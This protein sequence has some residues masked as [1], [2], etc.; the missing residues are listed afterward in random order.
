[1]VVEET[2]SNGRGMPLSRNG[3]RYASSPP[4]RRSSCAPSSIHTAGRSAS[5]LAACA[6]MQAAASASDDTVASKDR[7]TSRGTFGDWINSL[8]GSFPRSLRLSGFVCVCFPSR[9]PVFRDAD[10][11]QTRI[12]EEDVGGEIGVVAVEERAGDGRGVEHILDIAH[13]LPAVLIGEDQRQVEIGVAA[14]AIIRI[15]VED[16]GPAV[17]LPVEIRSQRAGPI[18]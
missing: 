10:A 18:R 13:R 3:G 17:V 1:M 2:V 7:R 15:V 16:A 4:C 12:G 8:I 11:D 6:G 5:P 14:D 9:S